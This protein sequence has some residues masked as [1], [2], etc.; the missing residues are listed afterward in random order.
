M[1]PVPVLTAVCAALLLSP[2]TH[3]LAAPPAATEAALAQRIDASIGQ[4]FRPDAPGAII[5]VQRD[6]KTI[7]R[8]AYGLANLATRQPLTPA[9]PMRLGSLTKQFTAVAVLMLADEGKLALSDEITRFLPDYPTHG[10][11][12][13]IEHLLTH[14]S[15]IPNF[16]ARPDYQPKQ[17]QDVTVDSMIAR[18]RDDPLQFDPGT[19]FSYS[20]S[21]YF[22][23]G[24][25]IEKASGQ[26]YA[27]FLAQRI[28]IPLGMGDTAY[29]GFERNSARRVAGYTS[30][31]GAFVPADA[32]SMTQPYAAGALVSTVDDLARWEAAIGAGKL[33]RAATWRKAFTPYTLTDGK[34]TRYGY[35]W[36]VGD[37]QGAPVISHGGGIN[38]FA[39][40]AARLPQDG[41]FVAVLENADGDLLTPDA[42][43][44]K[45]AAIAIGKPLPEY[46]PIALDPAA[47]PAF[48][49][50]YDKD[51]KN[52]HTI[53]VRDNGLLL[54]RQGGQARRLLPYAPGAF[55]IEHTLI[56][57]QFRRAADGAVSGMTIDDG[58]TTMGFDRTGALTAALP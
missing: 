43:A 8:K 6:G 45:A 46:R 40:Y 24:A 33:L 41:V 39:T 3:V 52:S 54:Q 29:E 53:S 28:F 37:W 7:L 36:G 30:S 35:G 16:T 4:Y 2:A 17:A 10:R 11:K 51:G 20:N 19:Q 14:T 13:T 1:R 44:R 56:T 32:L 23:L 18:F 48:T 12:I 50:R 25:I 9:A 34:S 58:D 15:G 57:V 22:L 47:L 5:L 21:G 27:Q 38:G 42:V 55:V 49:G 26:P 31:G